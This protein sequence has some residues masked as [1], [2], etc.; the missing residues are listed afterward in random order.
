M[1][2]RTIIAA[3]TEAE[4]RAEVTATVEEANMTLTQTEWETEVVA[5]RRTM[6]R[7]EW[8][9][10]PAE[11]GI[12]PDGVPVTTTPMIQEITEKT[13]AAIMITRVAATVA[14]EGTTEEVPVMITNLMT[15]THE[16]EAETTVEVIQATP[17]LPVVTRDLH[18]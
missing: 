5:S 13:P 1:E 17:D 12:S 14:K 18:R 6:T 8:D 15:M 2:T 3:S 10:R 4:V 11:P 9:V 7:V 16:V